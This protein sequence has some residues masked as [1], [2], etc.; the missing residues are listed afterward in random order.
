M[1][2]AVITPYCREDLATLQRCHDSVLSQ[3]VACDHFL[4]ADGYPR[5][6]VATWRAIHFVLPP[7]TDYGN[8]PRLIG[9]VSADSLGY[10]AIAL[11]DADNWFEAIHIETLLA[12]RSLNDAV[13]VTCARLL[14]DATDHSILG[15][16]RESDGDTFNDTNCY[17]LAR[18]AFPL[19]RAWTTIDTRQGIVGE[20]RVLADRVFWYR[21]KRSG[22]SRIHSP[23]PTVVYTASWAANYRQFGREPPDKSKVLVRSKNGYQIVSYDETLKQ[24]PFKG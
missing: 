19:F 2:I 24:S 3:S 23:R 4:I 12:L 5:K 18:P 11:L 6:E 16:C 14:V 9:S 1:K 20:G 17:L 8:T 21:I 13:V 22:L 10:D 7:H 15:T